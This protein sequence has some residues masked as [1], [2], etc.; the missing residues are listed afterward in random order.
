VPWW[1]RA[2]RR[3]APRWRLARRLL[4]GHWE[5]PVLD[6]VRA[7]RVPREACRADAQLP[8]YEV[9]CEHY[10]PWTWPA[11]GHRH[12]LALC[13]PSAATMV[14]EAFAGASVP[15]WFLL[16]L[17]VLPAAAGYVADLHLWLVT[18]RRP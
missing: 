9:R 16:A 2:L 5:R 13:A 10:P 11:W 12:N 17:S 1:R 7:R 14:V 4:G 18:R 6:G 15:T 8:P 3:A